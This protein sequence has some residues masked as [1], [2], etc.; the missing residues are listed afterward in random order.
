LCLSVEKWV[1]V[2]QRVR[3]KERGEADEEEQDVQ[4]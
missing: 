2:V 4:E 3:R 1:T